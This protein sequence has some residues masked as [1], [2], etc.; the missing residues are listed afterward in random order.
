MICLACETSNRPGAD[1]CTRCARPLSPTCHGCGTSVPAGQDLCGT[2]RTERGTR[3][4]PSVPDPLD[5]L[6]DA[7]AVMAPYELRPRFVG[8]KQTLERM[9][10]AF[11]DAKALGEAAFLALIGAP[12]AGKT[13]LLDELAR[14]IRQRAPETR[15]LVGRPGAVHAQPYS[16]FARVFAQRF[17]ITAADSPDAAQQKLLA[18][19]GQV[20]PA[21]K[22]TE[23]G[24]LLGHVMR[25]PFQDSP[26]LAPLA[27]APQQL[28]ARCFI[29]V[30][31]FLAAD[32][33]RTPL[34]VCVDDLER[35]SAETVNLLHY[36]A[37]GLASSP[38]VLIASGR[39][40][41]YDVHPSFG[42]GEAP[43]V[44]LD[45]GALDEAEAEELFRELLRP[46]GR[47]PESLV[48][49]AKRVG[50]LPRTLFELTRLLIEAEV[51]TRAPRSPNEAGMT[52]RLDHVALGKLRL[53]EHDEEILT[54]RLGQMAPAE[55]DLLEKAAVCGEV[56]WL[57]AVV[58][59]V[60]VSALEGADPDGP[61]LAEI[62]AAGDRTRLATAQA[63]ERLV[64][65]E[66][67]GESQESMLPGE[68]QYQFAYPTLWEIV[69]GGLDEGSRRNY[70]R[71]IAQW[72][73]L[74]EGTR[75]DESVEEVGRHLEHAGEGEAA[76]LRY[77]RA[78]DAA[79][80]G[81]L[82]ERAIRLYAQALA[83]LAEGDLAARI[84]I[85]HDLGS[86][87]D[88]KG[89]FEAALAAFERM[90]RLTWVV[91]SRTK[92]A[93]AFNKM[94]RVFRRKGDLKTALEYLT[95][96]SELFE[97]AGDGRGVAGSLDDLGYTMW[98]MGR[99]DEAFEK[100]TAGLAKRGK[101]GDPRSIAHSLSNLGN[102][103]RDRGKLVEA[104][105]CYREALATRQKIGDRAGVVTS[106]NNLAVLAYGHGDRDRARQGWEQALAEAEQIGAL[107]LQAMAL[108]NLGELALAENK[109][110]EARRRLDETVN[111][112]RDLDDRLLQT[113]ALRLLGLLELGQGNT[114][115]ARDFAS[116][117]LEI[118]EKAGLRDYVGRALLALAEVHA[119]TLFDADETMTGGT[120]AEDFF[121]RGIDVF[122]GLG[123]DG[124]LAKGLERFGRYKLE[125]GETRQGKQL[126]GEA[127]SLFARLGVRPPEELVR[128]LRG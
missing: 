28:E 30:K 6:D 121:Q 78:A 114:Q 87:Y 45:L 3:R 51:I 94:G 47:P 41:L 25:L 54:L 15:V 17:G 19:V 46:I 106:L 13:R 57:D 83:C 69:Y 49:H 74:R 81:Y 2:C 115:L 68:R 88:L 101:A 22:V 67:L 100:I 65:R 113:E 120:A 16:A 24:H 37:A 77:R 90:L 18:G 60:R 64:E 76:A 31:R 7:T 109:P 53:P 52:W 119:A 1:R 66:W 79:R 63:L 95:R 20:L 127:Q 73:E 85:W 75:G 9:L 21:S 32:A 97:Q 58:A 48:T 107:P 122:R 33:Q 112:A 4:A 110:E 38:V 92:A 12:G 125:R 14:S 62:T 59:L 82:N 98:L 35:A 5:G 103:Q 29:A 55:R 61:S 39:P 111:I 89:D 117:S 50:G 44:R 93:V 11:D 99:Y 126:L 84:Q 8:R 128:A 118:A 96:G 80:L 23:V 123:N 116:R 10:G 72:L 42:D 102:V 36:L 43:L 70:H 105:N 71:L 104:E 40:T 34:V 86:V 124:E 27:E 91:S 26:I 56:F 108:S